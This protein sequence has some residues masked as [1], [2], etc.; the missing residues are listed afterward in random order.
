MLHSHISHNG[1]ARAMHISISICVHV[2]SW[3]SVSQLQNRI[4]SFFFSRLDRCMCEL[5]SRQQEYVQT[6][7]SRH[8]RRVPAPSTIK[9]VGF[10]S[11][12]QT[13]TLSD[14]VYSLSN[15]LL[16]GCKCINLLLL[17]LSYIIACFHGFWKFS[18]RRE[19]AITKVHKTKLIRVIK[20]Q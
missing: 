13:V 15:H 19:K 10:F 11:S 14:S 12:Q 16:F 2:C 9:Y 18:R 5:C 7:S 20:S 3:A 8:R 17:S 4:L 6:L 1:I